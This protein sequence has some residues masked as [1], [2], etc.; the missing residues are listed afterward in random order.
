MH[1]YAP[2]WALAGAPR[3]PPARGWRASLPGRPELALRMTEATAVSGIGTAARS[4]Q[5]WRTVQVHQDQVKRVCAAMLHVSATNTSQ[6]ALRGRALLVGLDGGCAVAYEGEAQAQRREQLA[7]HRLAQ[8]VVL[9]H[10]HARRPG[11]QRQRRSGRCRRR[12]RRRRRRQLR[13]R[14]RWRRRRRHR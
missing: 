5:R 6:S 14:R 10:Q 1:G 7:H 2:Q 8:L 3:L 12:G 11:I 13:W 4:R 9:G